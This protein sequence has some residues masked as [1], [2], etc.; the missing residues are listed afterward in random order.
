MRS[1]P[2]LARHHA[3]SD[4]STRTLLD[5]L[6]RQGEWTEAQYMA[7]I[8]RRGIEYVDGYLEILPVPTTSHQKALRAIYLALLAFVTTHKLGEA[9]FSGTRL[10]LPNGK[11]REPDIIFVKTEH[12]NWIEEKQWNGADL[13]MEIVTSPEGRT[14]D[15]SEKPE[16]YALA[17][18]P[19]C[20]IVDPKMARISVLKLSGKKYV[21][22]GVFKKGQRATSALLKG[23]NLDVSAVFNAD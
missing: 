9:L 5:V 10:R 23:F 15:I 16:D 14:R 18:I 1:V 8:D 4:A 21:K 12:L 17:G 2:N 20:W 19:E 3:A 22:H 11:F 13:V 7:L 6:P